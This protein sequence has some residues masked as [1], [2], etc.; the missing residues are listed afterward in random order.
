MIAIRTIVVGF[1][2]V[3]SHS[4][5][6]AEQQITPPQSMDEVERCKTLHR[7]ISETH[8]SDGK[9]VRLTREDGTQINCGFG[10][11]SIPK[12]ELRL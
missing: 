7:F 5:T 6:Y 2:T 11:N 8:Q 1:L 3:A 4:V 10:I 9:T 12:P